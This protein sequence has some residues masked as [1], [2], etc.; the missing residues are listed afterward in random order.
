MVQCKC[1]NP[2]PVVYALLLCD[3]LWHLIY[4]NLPCTYNCV[5]FWTS[6]GFW[7][8]ISVFLVC[9]LLTLNLLVITR[10]SKL[11]IKIGWIILFYFIFTHKKITKFLICLLNIRALLLWKSCDFVS[12]SLVQHQYNIGTML[13]YKTLVKWQFF[14]LRF[15][16]TLLSS[17]NTEISFCILGFRLQCWRVLEKG[18]HT[19][20]QSFVT[21]SNISN[22]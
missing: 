1:S 10:K 14:W 16:D 2:N 22:H 20:L 11:Q 7:E 15:S 21:R 9:F 4:Q 18:P 5:H 3:I 19:K 6:V 17:S 12:P 8:L 13:I